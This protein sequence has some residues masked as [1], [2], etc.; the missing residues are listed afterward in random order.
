[1]K[2]N[3]FSMLL[4]TPCPATRCAIHRIY[5]V[6][7][8]SRDMSRVFCDLRSQKTPRGIL[9]VNSNIK[10]LHF[11]PN[12]QRRKRPTGFIRSTATTRYSSP[13]TK[14]RETAWDKNCIIQTIKKAENLN[15][16][17]AFCPFL[18][19]REMGLEPTRAYTHKI[20]SLACLPIPAL[21]L[22]AFYFCLSSESLTD[23]A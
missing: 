21:P 4:F 1:M 9:P 5:A 14:K 11:H 22:T 7:I 23:E 13:T 16:I 18:C 10:T 3:I 19:M 8:N 12:Q 17:K 2:Q 20:L 15:K 6:R